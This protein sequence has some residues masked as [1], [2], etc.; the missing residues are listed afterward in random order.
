MHAYL[1]PPQTL[2]SIC[3]IAEVLLTLQQVGNVK[4]TGWVLQVPCS[5]N[6]EVINQLGAQAKHMEEELQQ[7]REKVKCRREDFYELNYYTTLQLLTLR[8]ELG[9]LKGGSPGMGGAV[10]SP[11]VLALLRSIS[12]HV[13][14]EVV[15]GAVCGVLAEAE[16][17]ADPERGAKAEKDAVLHEPEVVEIEPVPAPPEILS[18]VGMQPESE[19]P[20]GNDK[21]RASLTEED[22]TPEQREIMANLCHRLNYKKQLVLRC[23]EECA[24]REMDMYDYQEWCNDKKMEEDIEEDSEEDY[25]ESSESDTSSDAEGSGSGSEAEEREFRY[26]SSKSL[27]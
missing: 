2:H 1:F 4:Y 17:V 24:G 26:S 12:A 14:P 21:G 7:W 5:T 6:R 8:K 25:E 23:F 11:N 18:S 10:V 3:R 9:A 13:T 19:E 22:L 16:P 27:L 15:S 20:L